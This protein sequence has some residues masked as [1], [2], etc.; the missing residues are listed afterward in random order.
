M[1]S[2]WGSAAGFETAGSHEVPE[3]IIE[4]PQYKDTDSIQ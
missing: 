2:L 3:N 4:I 1:D